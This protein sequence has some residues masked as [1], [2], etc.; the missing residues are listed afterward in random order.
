MNALKILTTAALVTVLG[1]TAACGGK[2]SSAASGAADSPNDA[3][4]KT[5]CSTL[6]GIPSGATPKEAV[7]RIQKIG[8]PS[9][10]SDSARQGYEKLLDTLN[11][12]PDNS[13]DTSL[14]TLGKNLST[15]D[16]AEVQAF[17][18]YFLKTCQPG[19]V[20][21]APSS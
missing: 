17:L 19:A 8:T 13:T 2:S 1:A 6:A 3:D 11:R 20:P 14:A 21:T 10:I 4:Q 12:L 16:Q 5:F 18:D 9:D 7:A 15:A